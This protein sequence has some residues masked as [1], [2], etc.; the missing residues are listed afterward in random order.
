[1]LLKERSDIR[2]VLLLVTARR[3]EYNKVE[4]LKK[5]KTARYCVLQSG[6]LYLHGPPL[7]NMYMQLLFLSALRYALSRELWS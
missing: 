7:G 3:A 4:H 2:R 5:E 6:K 1:M